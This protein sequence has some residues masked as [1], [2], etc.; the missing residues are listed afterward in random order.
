MHIGILSGPAVLGLALF[1]TSCDWPDMRERPIAAGSNKTVEAAEAAAR[2]CGV[3]DT[4]IDPLDNKRA[5]LLLRAEN[6]EGP[7]TCL[8]RW[9]ASHKADYDAELLEQV[10]AS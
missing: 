4:R 6:S 8:A 9:L 7:E 1:V 10:R 2:S 3:F 5:V